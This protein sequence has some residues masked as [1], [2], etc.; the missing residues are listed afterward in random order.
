MLKNMTFK[1]KGI[2]LVFGFLLIIL[3]VSLVL[4]D[5]IALATE[6]VFNEIELVKMKEL[7]SIDND[8]FVEEIVDVETDE[9]DDVNVPDEVVTPSYD[10]KKDKKY[11]GY[12]EIPKISMIAGFRNINSPYNKVDYGLEVLSVSKMPDVKKS[13]FILAGHSGDS[14]ISYFKNLYKLSLS[15]NAY[16]TY[17][18]YTYVYSIVDIYKVEKKRAFSVYR[19]FDKNTLTLITCTRN[20]KTSQ[21]VYIL[22]LIDKVRSDS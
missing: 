19:D 13:N 15:D 20:D 1:F 4:Y 11:L 22:E 5:K 3:S 21:T 18:G 10:I 17:K 16:V 2:L 7:D 9:V 6:M 8:D 14:K 12:I